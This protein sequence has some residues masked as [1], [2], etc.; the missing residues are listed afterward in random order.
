MKVISRLALIF[1]LSFSFTLADAQDKKSPVTDTEETEGDLSGDNVNI[2][3]SPLGFVFGVANLAA[4]FKLAERL[5]LGPTV[6]YSKRTS[7]TSSATAWSFGATMTLYLSDP[8]MN[9]SWFI[10][11]FFQYAIASNGNLSASG[12]ATGLDL[13]YWWFFDSGINIALGAGIQYYSIDFSSIGIGAISS[14][15]PSLKFSIGYAF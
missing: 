14:L 3:I 6:S 5:S 4:E 8:A 10:S 7:G 9:D 11:P 12:I 2:Y 15:L 13:G 1:V